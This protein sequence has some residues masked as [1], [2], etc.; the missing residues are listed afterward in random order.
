MK[1]GICHICLEEKPLTFE[2]YPPS[3]SFN[4]G[5]VLIGDKISQKGIGGYTLCEKCNNL[6]GG[7]Y[8][9]DFLK[10]SFSVHNIL[11]KEQLDLK[12]DIIK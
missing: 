1:K 11:E 3:K 8:N 2:H 5:R 12:D 7:W 9:N 10:L 6:T 4:N